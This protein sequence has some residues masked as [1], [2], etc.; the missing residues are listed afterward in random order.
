[1]AEN[2]DFLIPLLHNSPMAKNNYIYFCAVFHNWSSYLAYQWCK[3][4][5]QKVLCLV[6]AHMHYRQTDRHVL[7]IAKHLL[8]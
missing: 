7:S 3:Q 8:H 1:M 6:T 4:I 5:L 2:H